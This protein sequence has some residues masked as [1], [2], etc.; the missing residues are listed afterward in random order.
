MNKRCSVFVLIVGLV[1]IAM[2]SV[3]LTEEPNASALTTNQIHRLA[4]K[5]LEN[6]PEHTHWGKGAHFDWVLITWDPNAN[7][8]P[9][10]DAV[11]N[12]LRKKYIV[13]HTVGAVPD[14]FRVKD[15]N[16]DLN[17]YDGGFDFSFA[18][19]IEDKNTVKVL[20]SDWEGILASSRHW[21]R[22]KWTDSDW[23]VIEKSVMMVS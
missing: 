4:L 22:Y 1:F 10:Q 5:I 23:V 2:C 9:I 14:K 6:T 19:T 21:K 15:S 20:Y 17:H 11:F 16:G 7:P 13:Y 12:L 8:T 3:G 18:V